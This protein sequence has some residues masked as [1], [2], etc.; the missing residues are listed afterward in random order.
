MIDMQPEMLESAIIDE[1]QKLRKP[2]DVAQIAIKANVTTQTVYNVF[3][4]K[5]ITQDLFNIM[6]EYYLDRIKM[7]ESAYNQIKTQNKQ[8]E[9]K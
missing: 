7:L 2:T 5:K 8:D 3:L 1:W 4:K 9:S 6:Q